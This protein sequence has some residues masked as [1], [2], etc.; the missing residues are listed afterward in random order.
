MTMPFTSSRAQ[1][2]LTDEERVW[3]QLIAQSRSESVSKVQRA[4]ILLRY[5]E[6][7]RVSAIAKSLRTNRPKVER[8]I[9][10]SLQF[11]LEIA[12]QD[13]PGRGRPASI[14]DEAKS[15]VVDLAC[16][17]PKELGYAQE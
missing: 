14:P 2:S 4:Q 10:K 7:E 16:R 5:S 17:K 6:G 15:W 9:S 12:L 3:L 8:C 11:G 13:L 1:L